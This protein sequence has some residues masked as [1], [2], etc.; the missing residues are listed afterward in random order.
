MSRAKLAVV[1]TFACLLPACG[2]DDD[3]SKAGSG[4]SAGSSAGSGGEGGSS[5]GAGGSSAGSGGSSG[6]SGGAPSCPSPPVAPGNSTLTLDHAGTQRQYTLHVPPSYAGETA[7]PL[8]LNFHGYGSNMGQQV[9]F[10]NMNAT[11]DAEGFVVVYP[12]GLKNSTNG[13]QSWN[14][15]LCCAFGDSDRDDVG[16]VDALIDDVSSRV[17][18]DQKRVYATGMSNGGFMSHRLACE[19]ADRIAAIGPVAGVLG[20]PPESCKPSRAVP[21]IHFHG[22]EDPLVPYDG[23]GTSSY[24]SVADTISGWA[25]RDG[26]T[27]QPTQTFS[28][29]AAHCETTTG[30]TGGAEVTLCTID[31][32]GHCWPGQSF[33]PPTLGSPSTD[34]SA[35]Q[36]M[37]DFFERFALP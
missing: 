8:V 17:C 10:S 5:A 33:C 20:I 18:I 19:R 32:M 6:G 27:S 4:G 34:I 1:L 22:T 25:S 28:N 36:A 13:M 3:D 21:V 7:V 14:A 11:A 23:G 2:G 26:C 16:F 31:G 12:D 9:L 35:N 30:C 37:W 29:G 15:G 24:P